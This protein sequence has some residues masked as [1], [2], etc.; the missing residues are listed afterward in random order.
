VPVD[1]LYLHACTVDLRALRVSREDGTSQ[2]LSAKEARL[3]AYLAERAGVPVERDVLYA[4]V[5]GHTKAVVTRA[6]DA[7]VLR[8]RHKIERDPKSPDHLLTA[9]GEGYKLVLPEQKQP[10]LVLV[11]VDCEL[12]RAPLGQSR[13]WQ[14]RVQQARD[15]AGG[16]LLEQEGDEQIVSFRSPARAVGFCLSVVEAGLPVGAR[17]AGCLGDVRQVRQVLAA[18]RAGGVVLSAQ[19]HSE[20]S[21]AAGVRDRPWR[22]VGVRLA[23][24][25]LEELAELRLVPGPGLRSARGNLAHQAQPLVGRA[26]ERADVL[27]RL[28]HTRLLTL[29]G[30]GG[31][32]KTRLALEVGQRWRQ[33]A[34]GAWFC[35]LSS[36]QTELDVLTAVAR[37]LEVPLTGG[38]DLGHAL[39]WLTDDLVVLDNAEQALPA[40]RAQVQGWLEE[41]PGARLLVT[42]REPLGLPGEEL[43]E[44]GALPLED[45]VALFVAR[46]GALGVAVQ[47]DEAVRALVLRVEG[48]PLAI[49]LA[50][51]RS[52]L[53]TPAELLRV[54]EQGLPS[55]GHDP[56]R[57]R[58]MDLRTLVRWSWALLSP[59]EQRVLSAACVFASPFEA[60][61]LQQVSSEGD[62][63]L[64]LQSALALR[65]KGLLQPVTARSGARRLAPYVAVRA[66]VLEQAD[67]ELLRSAYARHARHFGR[68]SPAEGDEAQRLRLAEELPDLRA[69]LEHAVAHG[70]REEA[71]GAFFGAFEVLSALG[72]HEEIEPLVQRVL[73]LC[74]GEELASVHRARLRGSP[75]PE[76]LRE[77]DEALRPYEDGRSLEARARIG[78]ELGEWERATVLLERAFVVLRER[79]DEAGLG[80][81]LGTQVKLCTFRGRW[82]Q[83][84]PALR[85]AVALYAAMGERRLECM[86]RMWL[87]LGARH[88]GQLD[89][90]LQEAQTA[91][92]LA[93]G[94]LDLDMHQTCTNTLSTVYRARGEP[95]PARRYGLEALELARRMGSRSQAQTT[96]VYLGCLSTDFFGSQQALAWLE[97]AR[98]LGAER[99]VASNG[100]MMWGWRGVAELAED[101]LEEAVCTLSRAIDGFL[102]TGGEEFASIFATHR[103]QA[104]LLQGQPELAR[105]DLD[106]AV[107][108]G[109]RLALPHVEAGARVWRAVAKA[110]RGEPAE[111]DLAAAAPRIG[112][113]RSG[114]G[115]VQLALCRAEVAWLAQDLA[116]ARALAGQ[117][118][119]ELQSREV[120][121]TTQLG[122]QL[123]RLEQRLDV[124]QR[125]MT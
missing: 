118:R 77:I 81:A 102:A 39:A 103:A 51:A 54:L 71:V 33:H 38:H 99:D 58:H 23:A 15:A 100:P 83:A 70:Q 104:R 6:L 121:P 98:A 61:A 25:P 94:T 8:L 62:D 64:V 42:S 46:A 17:G 53:L 123:R 3:L 97:Q 26:A 119:R 60:S 31:V 36:C 115:H 85:E 19:L 75:E 65:R 16:V 22:K 28:Q 11:A 63:E 13:E 125:H 73:P 32:G 113:L 93:E 56:A 124:A 7:M 2:P 79:R 88:L 50:A 90:L 67:P 86:A 96:L 10:G 84:M 117:A 45:G 80:A 1:H 14:E 101:R 72:P 92:A 27:D 87:V 76:H 43:L 29:T 37:A 59:L 35:D 112:S 34:G 20:V 9:H 78:L 12:G 116:T 41:S 47:D 122:A 108:R 66:F 74:E 111:E 109:E 110:W 30:T 82:D 5:W 106:H 107:E 89:E 114:L 21:S 68:R 49:E 95:G 105:I 57:P 4:E 91:Y 52:E 18:A 40:V 48:L 44:L 24:G 120:H 55:L 69:A